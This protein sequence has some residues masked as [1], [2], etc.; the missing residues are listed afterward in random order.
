MKALR[1]LEYAKLLQL[2]D[3]PIP[4]P[5]SGKAIIQILAANI[6]SYAREIYNGDRKYPYPTP[7]TIGGSAVGRVFDLPLD[8]TSLQKNDLVLIDCTYRSRDDPSHVFLSG[9]IEGFTA[10]SKKLM[11]H[12]RDSTYAEYT[13]VP[14]ENY[15]RL[16]ENL[17]LGPTS[18]GGHNY[19]ISDLL[20]S[21]KYLVPFGGFV[22]INLR[23]SETVIVAPATGPFGTAAVHL[24]LSL[25][26]R[27]IA[28]GR[29]TTTLATIQST[30]SPLFPSDRLLTVPITGDSTQETEA[31]VKAAGHFPIDAY[32]DISPPQAGNSSHIKA[33]V[34][35]LRHG[36]RIS[37]MGGIRDDIALPHSR[38][39]HWNMRIEGKWMFEP[40]DVKD[41]V[42]LIEFGTLQM[43]VSA[44]KNGE[45]HS[46][47]KR[48]VLGDW[49]EAL[50]WAAE[51][52]GI[53]QGAYFKIGE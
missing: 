29:N 5:E 6:L 20:S 11:S 28:M 3:V 33:A 17:L 22:T 18:N 27:V 37:L 10:G 16:N 23:P 7:L 40:Q 43:N 12:W 42:R 24:A 50:D 44:G 25:G 45:G 39:M 53:G 1:Q 14:L 49:K 9:I 13:S 4:P 47:M 48:F 30:F 8:S 26:C 35:A 41:L 36:A 34:M 52:T 15:Y 51:H 32:F 31:L 21:F 19:S 2:C 46:G 38:I